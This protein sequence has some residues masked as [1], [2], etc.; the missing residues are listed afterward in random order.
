MDGRKSV[1]TPR[2]GDIYWAYHGSDQRRPVVVVSREDLN[3]G[4]YVVVVPFTST[5]LSE[6]QR[7][8]NCVPIH[9]GSFGLTKD[10]VA[11][12]EAIGTMK[13]DLLDPEPL[14]QLTDTVL[15][16]IVRAIGN[17]ISADCEPV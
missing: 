2:P 10:C 4:L 3:R 5:R 6:R 9:A 11:Q 17:S 8:P 15:R 12:A 7:L 13:K 16:D 14:D 1:L